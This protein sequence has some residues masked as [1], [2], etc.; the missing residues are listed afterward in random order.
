MHFKISLQNM[1]ESSDQFAVMFI[2]EMIIEEV[3]KIDD[4]TKLQAIK[5]VHE[6]SYHKMQDGLLHAYK[7]A[8][9]LTPDLKKNINK[10]IESCPVLG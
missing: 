5:K 4:I 10:I 7:N 9:M 8:D 2:E 3:F 6:N 1:S